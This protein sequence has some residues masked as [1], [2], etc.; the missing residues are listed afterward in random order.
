[1]ENP[2]F[3]YKICDKILWAEAEE[4][5]VFT[6]ASIDLTDGFIHFST[7]PQVA[8]TLALHFAGQ[9]GLMLIEVST[10]QLDILYEPARGGELFPHLYD[11]LPLEHVTR[12]WHLETDETGR[13]ILPI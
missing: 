12:T 13:H 3:I 1:M 5:A 7:A 11:E 9:T 6:G 2:S 4:R 8:S 10:A